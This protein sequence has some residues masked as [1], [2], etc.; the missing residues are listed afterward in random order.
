[1]ARRRSCRSPHRPS[2]FR[3]RCCQR[4]LPLRRQVVRGE[5]R[6]R[7]GKRARAA[8][9]DV[10]GLIRTNRPLP[11]RHIAGGSRPR[12]RAGEHPRDRGLQRPVVELIRPGTAWTAAPAPSTVR[13]GNPRRRDP[14]RSGLS[15]STKTGMIVALPV[16]GVVPGD[17]GFEVR[18]EGGEHA[19]AGVLGVAAVDDRRPPGVAAAVE[20]PR[21]RDVGESGRESSA[22]VDRDRL[23]APSPGFWSTQDIEDV[24]G[25]R[26]RR[27]ARFP[28]P[29]RCRPR[30]RP[31]S[32]PSV[33]R[34]APMLRRQPL[35]DLRTRDEHDGVAPA[36][37]PR[38]GEEVV[39][40][41]GDVAGE[42][43]L[44]ALGTVVAAVADHGTGEVGGEHPGDR[45]GEES[46]GGRAGR[47]TRWRLGWGLSIPAV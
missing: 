34:T 39:A 42:A 13:A 21:R 46:R 30:R 23:S 8:R 17:Q 38:S 9:G 19:D 20:L 44:Q 47:R 45:V 15:T 36:E 27:P 14:A 2:A 5:L 28:G 16:G 26:G 3:T 29:A 4:R 41:T 43:V 10:R 11:R 31:G 25:D 6:H 35:F 12:H 1:V 24:G 32:R 22:A 40:E 33:R 7:P 37:P 18:I